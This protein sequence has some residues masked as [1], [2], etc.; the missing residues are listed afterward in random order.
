M[1]GLIEKAFDGTTQMEIENLI[2]GETIT[3]TINENLTNNEI[4]RNI[5]NI[6]SL[7]YMT[8]YLTAT[9]ALDGNWYRLRIPI[10]K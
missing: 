7:L 3:K 9:G 10:A 4:D 8:G 6:W 5:E 2:A 1:K